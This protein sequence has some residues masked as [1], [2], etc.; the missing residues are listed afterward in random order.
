MCNFIKIGKKMASYGRLCL[1]N[2]KTLIFDPL[3]K[4][5]FSKPVTILILHQ[6]LSFHMHFHQHWWK[7]AK[8]WCFLLE[9]ISKTQFLTECAKTT[10]KLV[11]FLTLL[12][13]MELYM[14]FHPD[15]HK[16]ASVMGVFIENFSKSQ[17]SD[18]LCAKISETARIAMW[19]L[20]L[21]PHA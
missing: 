8:L 12:L 1:K 9:K 21:C 15:W 14:Q 16:N 10:Q 3:C 11:Q 13:K 2:S 6:K 20:K 18:L 19:H 5:N 4:T 7:I 17:F